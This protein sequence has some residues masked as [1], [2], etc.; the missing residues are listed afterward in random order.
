MNFNLKKIKESE[1]LTDYIDENGWITEN[2][3]NISEFSGFEISEI[4]RILTIMQTFEPDGIFARNLKE[5]LKIQIK[6]QGNA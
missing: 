3:V 1:I 2:L 5:C 6:K 4:E